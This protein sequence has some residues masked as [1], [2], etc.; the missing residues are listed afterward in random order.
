MSSDGRSGRR[1]AAV[2]FVVPEQ[3]ANKVYEIRMWC[4]GKVPLVVKEVAFS[5]DSSAGPA[6]LAESV[7]DK[8]PWAALSPKL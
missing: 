1:R 3:N 6:E 7:L 8:T 2:H 5:R 4:A